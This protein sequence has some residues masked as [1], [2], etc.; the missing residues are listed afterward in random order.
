MTTWPSKPYRALVGTADETVQFGTDWGVNQSTANETAGRLGEGSSP[1]RI[2]TGTWKISA[3][4]I[5]GQLCKVAEC[6]ANGRCYMPLSL[7]KAT[8]TE[9][10]YGTWVWWVY[11]A[12]ASVMNIYDVDDYSLANDSGYRVRLS[13]AEAALVQVRT[14]G[15]TGADVIDSGT[16][17]FTADAWHRFDRTRT[18]AGGFYLYLDGASLGSGTDNTHTTAA[19]LV[20]DAD[21]GDKVSW[22]D[23][24]GDHNIS[25]Q[26]GVVAP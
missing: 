11:K 2:S 24:Q 19:Y 14:T 23:L 5:E 4:T 18:L 13:N 20:I 26:L 7:L 9:A 12:D 3:S 10:A 6:V 8:P 22:S 17:A 16:G 1:L 21:A 25:K 15:G